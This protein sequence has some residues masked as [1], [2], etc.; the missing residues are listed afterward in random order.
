MARFFGVN[1]GIKFFYDCQII[2]CTII[3]KMSH[4][5]KKKRIAFI[6]NYEMREFKINS[7]GT[8]QYWRCNEKKD[9][10]A[11]GISEIGSLD[12]NVTKPHNHLPNPAKHSVR[13]RKLVLQHLAATTKENPR[14]IIS[15]I[16]NNISGNF[17]NNVGLNI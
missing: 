2:Y 5:T 17:F 13:E 9:C 6:G 4:T 12:V 7:L 16:R 11:W 1:I 14:N 10:N 8:L 3:N 15:T